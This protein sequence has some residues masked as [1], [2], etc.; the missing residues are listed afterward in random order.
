[1]RAY[2]EGK[3]Y[4]R[5]WILVWRS[6]VQ[7]FQVSVIADTELRLDIMPPDSLFALP[8]IFRL[9]KLFGDFLNKQ[10]SSVV[11]SSVVCHNPLFDYLCVSD[12]TH[13]LDNQ[14]SGLF[15]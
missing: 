14:G 12:Q 3:L 9:V 13:A 7:V 2:K 6:R 4:I 15:F 8:V 10:C 5:C 11:T 1:M